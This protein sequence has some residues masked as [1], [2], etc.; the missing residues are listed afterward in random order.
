MNDISPEPKFIADHMLGSLSRW[1]R[2]LG[3]DCRYEKEFSDEEIL[4]VS[5]DENRVILT[6]DRELAARGDSL[7]IDS[8]ALDEQLIAVTK[9]YRLR[10]HPE[11]MR[12]S[13]CNGRLIEIEPEQVPAEIP[14]RS[15]ENATSFWKCEGCKKIYWDGT[16]WHGILQRFKRLKLAEDDQ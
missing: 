8:T 5:Q 16:H 3:Y 10:F 9:D 1:L 2:M 4:K 11:N 13:L 14:Q 6:R 12:C 15:K 7:F